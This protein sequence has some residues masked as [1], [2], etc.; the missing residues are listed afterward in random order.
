MAC[1][2]VTRTS[3]RLECCLQAEACVTGFGEK[4]GKKKAKEAK[5]LWLEKSAAEAAPPKS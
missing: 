4:K 2:T 1:H 3:V 5:P